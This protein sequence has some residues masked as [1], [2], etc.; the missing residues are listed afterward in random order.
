MT[1]LDREFTEAMV[2]MASSY[3]GWKGASPDDVGFYR[4]DEDGDEPTSAELMAAEQRLSAAE[5]RRVA[6]ELAD[7]SITGIRTGI[8]SDNREAWLAARKQY[9]CG[10]EVAAMLGESPYADAT[11]GSVV[12][13]KAGLADPFVGTEQTKLG[14]YLEPAVAEFVRREWGWVLIRCGELI[15]DAESECLAATPDYLVLT[16]WGIGSVQIKCTVAMAQEDCKPRKDG[17]PS[18]AAYA[19]GAPLHHQLQ[20]QAELACL[21]LEWSTLLVLHAAGPG[22]KVRAYS[23]RRHEGVIAR[24]RGEAAALMAEVKALREGQVKVA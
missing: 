2:T 13:E 22:M 19:N 17:Q 9:V 3:D 1:D 5:R 12:M 10:S 23:T 20:Q 4:S 11:R 21:G 16:P 6:R 18:T 15:R 7:E 24:I 8:S 14:N